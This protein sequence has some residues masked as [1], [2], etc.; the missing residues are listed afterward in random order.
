V[1]ELKKLPLA[2]SEPSSD[3]CGS[4]LKFSSELSDWSDSLSDPL[5]WSDSWSSGSGCTIISSRISSPTTFPC[6]H[7]PHCTGPSITG[8][9][10]ST[11]TSSTSSSLF[12]LLLGASQTS[13]SDPNTGL[14]WWESWV[15]CSINNLGIS[16]VVKA[17]KS[18]CSRSSNLPENRSFSLNTTSR[19][20]I[21]LLL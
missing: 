12:L 10:S 15:S 3:W 13:S 1:R 6:D 8:S 14:L 17:N 5:I 9:A 21:T 18:S 16:S 20:R 4:E 2:Q 11:A 19:I 7:L